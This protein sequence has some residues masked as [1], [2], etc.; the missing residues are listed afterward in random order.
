MSLRTFSTTLIRGLKPIENASFVRQYATATR[1]KAHPPRRTYLYHKY[2][3]LIQDNR[4]MFIFQH[5]NLSV[6]E[7]TQLRQELSSLDGPLQLTVLRSGVFGS[8][9][10]STKY[11][12]LEP[13]IMGPTCVLTSNIQDAEHPELLKK[14]MA[15]LNKNK[16]MMLLGGKIDNTLLTQDDVQ[17]IVQ[18]PGLDMLRAELLGTI[19][20]PAR[21]ILG[22]LE[23]PAKQLHSVLDRRI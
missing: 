15:V 9:L 5:N 14:A 21:K 3:S 20:A 17:K 7:F 23:S 18:L 1:S 11:S 19:E 4:V 2:G 12:N 13:L 10:R 8:V 6:T 22:L 16:K